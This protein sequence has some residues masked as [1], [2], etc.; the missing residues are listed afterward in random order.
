MV[1]FCRVGMC[2]TVMIGLFFALDN[3][4]P[5][6]YVVRYQWSLRFRV[7]QEQVVGVLCC[8]DASIAIVEL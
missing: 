6:F 1:C 7:L 4:T 8:I 3:C 2:L 5:E